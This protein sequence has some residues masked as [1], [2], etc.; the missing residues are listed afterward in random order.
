MFFSLVYVAV[1]GGL[2]LVVGKRRSHADKDVELMV[3]R[4][5]VRILEQPGA[6]T[7]PLPASDRALLAALS[8]LLPRFR[9]SRSS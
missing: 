1:R 9:W 4:H 5:Q 8:R 2:G 7:G 6:W 3:L